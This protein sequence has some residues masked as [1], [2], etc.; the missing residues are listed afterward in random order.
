M[1][2]INVWRRVSLKDPTPDVTV[3]A[4]SQ[5]LPPECGSSAP[6]RQGAAKAAGIPIVPA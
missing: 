1:P 4:E 5:V 3:K 2:A 6:F